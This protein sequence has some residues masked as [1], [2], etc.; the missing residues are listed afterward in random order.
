MNL[1][2]YAE[3]RRLL[4]VSSIIVQFALDLLVSYLYRPRGLR[5][6]SFSRRMLAVAIRLL[7]RRPAG[8][9]RFPVRLRQTIE[10]LGPTYVKLGQI[11]SLREDLLPRRI[12]YEL[13]NLQTKVPP[14]TYEEA[15]KVIEGEFNVPLRHIFKEFAPKPVG[16]A[17]LAQAHIAYLRNGQKVV[18]KVQRPGIIPV[19]TNDLRLMKRL[20]WILQ[21]I[22]Y[23]QDFQPQKLIQEFSDYTMK[24][25]DFTQEGKHADIFRENFKDNDD[26]ILPKVYW[27]Y[28]T[29]KVLTLEF[30]EGV[31]PD[32][33]EKLKKLGINGPKVAALGARVVIKQLFI[34]GFF[35]GDPH[36]GNLFIV[37]SE[38]F[39]MID[40]GMIGQFSQKTMNAMFL[41]YYYLI[42]RDYETA[43]KYMV[44][45]TET[46]AHSDIAGFRAEIEEIGKRWIGAGFKNY[47]LGKLILNSMNMGARYKL[48]FNTD[49]MLAI[50]AIVTIE[51]V[52]FILDPKMDLAKVSLPIMS[53]IF[54]GRISPMRMTKPILRAL[55]D[56]LDFL[57]QA[58][59]TLLKTL[60]M[61]STGKFQIEM[62]E[63]TEKQLPPEPAW[64]LWIPF[65]ALGL[66]IFTLSADNP[67][68][69]ELSIG[70]NSHLP[71]VSAISF[72]I[73]AWYSIR[74]WRMRR[75]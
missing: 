5:K 58:P 54:V 13:R 38:K 56:Y 17:S 25:L 45:L 66:G 72:V 49:I 22:P 18:V 61:V 1:K 14:I 68:G 65:V 7:L 50:K 34:D 2:T 37:G 31:K 46:T 28:T 69:G 70:K 9:I 29:R 12:T 23:I 15:K 20:A 35:H 55:P 30:I 63:K 40:L 44:G 36:P 43:S 59:A 67:P 51:A 74:F 26:V 19:M 53:E 52:G 16:A 64:K 42:I 73:A 3:I 32:D 21:Q 57:E 39:C 10:R 75:V 24:E 33:S 48:Y 4:T 6:R 27:E 8:I 62:V 11:L 60:G 47:S 41:Y 71:W